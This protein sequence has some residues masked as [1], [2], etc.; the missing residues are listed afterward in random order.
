MMSADVSAGKVMEN[1]QARE[2]AVP[3]QAEHWNISRQNTPAE[4]LERAG[5]Q[6]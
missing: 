6:S 5:Q 2:A 3:L 1:R 4:A